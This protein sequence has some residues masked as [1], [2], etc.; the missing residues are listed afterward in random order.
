MYAIGLLEIRN[1]PEAPESALWAKGV[2]TTMAKRP[3]SYPI[4]TWI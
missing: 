4:R 3:Y 2:A 1:D